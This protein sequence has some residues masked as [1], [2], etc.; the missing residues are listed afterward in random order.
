MNQVPPTELRVSIKLS[1][2]MSHA[3]MGWI[4]VPYGSDEERSELIQ[5]SVKRLEELAIIT[6]EEEANGE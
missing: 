1:E 5:M 4:P 6:E 2:E 3:G